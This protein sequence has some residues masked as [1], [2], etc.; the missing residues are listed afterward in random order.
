MDYSTRGFPVHH[1]LLELTQTYVHRI[2]DAIQPSHPLSSP[3]PFAFT[4]S[5]HQSISNE[6][7]LCIRWPNYQSFSFSISPPNEYAGLFPLGWTGWISLQSKGLSRLFCKATV[8]NHQFFGI[9]LSLCSPTLTSI[10]DYWKTIALTRL[11]WQ[12]N[13]PA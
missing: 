3:S 5:Q 8:Q 13:V 2:S 4:L 9:Q 12:S 1:Q 10:H 6:L 7:V 11:C